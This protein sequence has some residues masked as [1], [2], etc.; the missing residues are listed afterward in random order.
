MHLQ[1]YQLVPCPDEE[2]KGGK[3]AGEER[4]G[5]QIASGLG[6]AVD[7]EIR[8]GDARREVDASR[9]VERGVG[10]PRDVANHLSSA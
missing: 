1:M 9:R 3:D 8:K 7:V 2:P 6:R 4:D 10:Q 5:S